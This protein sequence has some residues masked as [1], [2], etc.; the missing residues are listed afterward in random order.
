MLLLARNTGRVLTHRTLLTSIWGPT[1]SNQPEYL[2]VLIA[3]LR[4]KIDKV[5][6]SS[7]IE[8]EPWVGYRFRAAY[9]SLT[10]S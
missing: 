8:S 1:G 9:D 6:G 4:K 7:Y 10:S 3:Q 5:D 2:R